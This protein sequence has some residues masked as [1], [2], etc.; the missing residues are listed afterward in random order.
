MSQ[1]EGAVDVGS[2]LVSSRHEGF[3]GHFPHR[4]ED[5]AVRDAASAQLVLHHARPL[6]VEIHCRLIPFRCA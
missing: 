6:P 5:S 4:R 2:L 1:G 3:A